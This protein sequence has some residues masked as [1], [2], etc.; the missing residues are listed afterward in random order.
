MFARFSLILLA[1]LLALPA[2]GREPK[3]LELK[4]KWKIGDTLRYEMTRT[5]VREVDGKV[6]RKVI[7][8]TPV[9]L[10]VFDVD[11]EGSLISWAQGS[12]IH[13]DPKT[14]DD[15][16][17][18]AIHAIQKGLDIDLDI[19][20][21][22]TMLGVRNWKDI[23]GTGHRVQ[24]FV[25]AQMAKS[26]TTKTTIE[27]LRK[28]TDKLFLTKESIEAA[29]GQPAALLFYPF[30]EEYELEESVPYD[31]EIPNVFGGEE[32]LPAKGEFLLKS[33]DKDDMIAVIVFKQTTDTQTAARV[34]RK[35]LDD[36]AQKTGKPAPKDLPE[37]TIE[38][39][40]E[41]EFDLMTGWPRSVTHTRTAKEGNKTQIET[42][43]L[44]RKK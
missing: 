16:R 35:W 28:E 17:A 39:V 23:R 25:F 18:R 15:P 9:A 42:V 37:F 27:T 36:T 34:L 12:T 26:G 11:E 43:T 21:D 13:D 8:R 29:F 22:G 33:I 32:P 14:D 20:T 7:T 4:P 10:E 19:D 24:D 1:G 38:D 31:G 2:L 30:G 44:V 5:L 3:I 6:V 41:Y 40:R